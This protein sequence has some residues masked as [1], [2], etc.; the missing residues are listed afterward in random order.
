M[1]FHSLEY[2]VF[3]VVVLL[4][5]WR[6]PTRAQNGM[7]LVASYVFYGW[8]HPWYCLLI[9]VTTLVDFTAARMIASRP[10][11]VRGRKRIMTCSLLV[12]FSI[13]C[14]F[15][16][17]NFFTEAAWAAFDAVGW[18]IPRPVIDVL[19]PVGISFYTFQSASYVVDVFRGRDPVCKNLMDYALFVSF[20]PQLVAGPIERA[21]HL[22]GQIQSKRKA[23]FCEISD[24]L[25]LIVWGMF[26]KL[27]I[28]DGAALLVNRVFSIQDASFPMVWGG[29]VAFG[30]Q[31]LAD[32]SAYTDIARGTAKLMGFDLME[33]FRHPYCA[34]S[35]VE[36]WRRWHISLST[37]FRD[38]VY[39][40]LGGSRRGPWRVALNLM[41]T[42]AI[43]GLWHGSNWNFVVWGVFH[44]ALVAG[45]HLWKY[46]RGG[47]ESPSR[48][49]QSLI[50]WLVTFVLIHIGWLLFREQ[51]SEYLLRY[52]SLSPFGVPVED[53]EMGLY[54]AVHAQL[55]AL[56]LWLHAFLGNR[57]IWGTL[58]DLA[59]KGW[60]PVVV[61]GV[62]LFIL[63]WAIFSLRAPATSE[64]IYF[65]F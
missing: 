60:M 10:R 48:W 49:W 13:L 18:H 4:V 12:T 45:Q 44:G 51:N 14:W 30:V 61:R 59:S 21:S 58:R 25:T 5:Y 56:P 7:L 54:F 22:L 16:Y 9:A 31:I 57:P 34:R 23:K 38:Y 40:P 3:L 55:L 47:E 41:F 53:W 32:F 15:K 36:F 26:K 65:Q 39:V 2:L 19:L 1:I 27:V 62:M 50:G 33:N 20:F 29:V 28:A 63:A 6:L 24:G 35:P 8:V 42:F 64:F 11:G 52:L 46:Y 37:W 17:F 43:S